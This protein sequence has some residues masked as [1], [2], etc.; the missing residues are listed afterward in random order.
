M[1]FTEK[2]IVFLTSVSRGR[3]PFGITYTIPARKERPVYMEETIAQ[4]K[5]RGLLNEEGELTRK[6]A[7]IIYLWERYRNS[8][9]HIRMNHMNIA[10]L[11]EQILIIVVRTEEGYEMQCMGKE[12]FMNGILKHAEF[13]Q[14]EEGKGERGRWQDMDD[15]AFVQAVSDIDGY[16]LLLTYWSGRLESEKIYYWK[17]EEGFLFLRRTGRVRTLSSAAMRRQIYSVLGEEGL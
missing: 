13:L 14:S 17:E 16:L 3:M 11:P 6:G 8:R 12:D 5:K 1:Y 7:D 2:E 9:R 4:L 15:A 10:V